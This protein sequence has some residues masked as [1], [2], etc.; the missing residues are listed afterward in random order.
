VLAYDVT[1]LSSTRRP[2][3]ASCGMELK[4]GDRYTATAPPQAPRVWFHRKCFNKLMPGST[5]FAELVDGRLLR[6]SD[7]N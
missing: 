2:I 6:K 5:G 1:G 4:P 3:C 7:G